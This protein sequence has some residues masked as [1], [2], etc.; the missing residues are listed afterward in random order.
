MANMQVAETILAQLGGRRFIVMTGAK[1][2]LGDERSLSF[3][4]PGAGG[5]TTDGINYVKVQLNAEDTYD[6]TF[7]RL[8]GVNVKHVA[9]RKSIYNDQLQEVFTRVTGLN[10]SLGTMG[11]FPASAVKAFNNRHE[12]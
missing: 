2:F 12:D 4:L 3:R 8:R 7:L 6:L 9:E 11:G 5:R 1:N 10:T